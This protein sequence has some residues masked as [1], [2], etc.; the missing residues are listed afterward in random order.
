[1]DTFQ[2]T[3]AYKSREILLQYCNQYEHLIDNRVQT[4]ITYWLLYQ[5]RQSEHVLHPL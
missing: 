2:D 5:S 1:M 3:Y 4:L